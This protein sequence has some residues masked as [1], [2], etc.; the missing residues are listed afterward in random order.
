MALGIT[1]YSIKLQQKMFISRFLTHRLSFFLLYFRQMLFM[2]KW[3]FKK[4]THTEHAKAMTA[5]PNMKSL[6]LGL[7]ISW[8]KQIIVNCLTRYCPWAV[9]PRISKRSRH[10]YAVKTKH[11]CAIAFVTECEHRRKDCLN[12][13]KEIRFIYAQ[14]EPNL[15]QAL[16]QLNIYLK[17]NCHFLAQLCL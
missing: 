2:I 3:G 16:T 11:I 4:Q 14:L 7:F 15:L 6:F 1:N 9:S 13:G 5:L 8:I 17:L 12:C 10:K